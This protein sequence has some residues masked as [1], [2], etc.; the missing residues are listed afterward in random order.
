ML[1]A[2]IEEPEWVQDM[3][4]TYLNMCIAHFEMILDA[5]Y[6]IDAITWPDD[7]GYKNTPFF[8]PAMYRELLMP[9]HKKAVDW[10]HNRGLYARL[11][12]CGDIHTL[13]PD[14]TKTGID[15]LN[16]IE[17]KAGMDA[18]KLKEEYGKT[19]WHK[20]TDYG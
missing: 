3:F 8:S 15:I 12:S 4:D 14:I 11:H 2:L 7:M 17:I 9:F 10:A 13:L 5:G 1:I 19:R 16:P 18:L 6:K 20:C